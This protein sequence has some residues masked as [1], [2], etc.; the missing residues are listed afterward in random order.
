MIYFNLASVMLI[1][2][3]KKNRKAVS[4]VRQFPRCR[5]ISR[6]EIE[7]RGALAKFYGP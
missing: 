1:N 4:F 3:V 7:N 5:S 6:G 2:L